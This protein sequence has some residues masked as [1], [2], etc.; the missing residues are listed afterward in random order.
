MPYRH[1]CEAEN[2]SR[3]ASTQS[4]LDVRLF[5]TGPGELTVHLVGELDIASAELVTALLR[6]REHTKTIRLDLAGLT[7]VDCAGL[8]ALE[9]LHDRLRCNTGRLVL[10]HVGPRVRQLL[11]MT[12]LDR[13]I[14]TLSHPYLHEGLRRCESLPY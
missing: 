5:D 1:G 8:R 11:R 3:I 14:S 2:G 12:G 7:F 10:A 9:A 4:M 13:E 6:C